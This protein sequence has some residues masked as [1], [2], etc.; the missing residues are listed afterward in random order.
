MAVKTGEV[1]EIYKDRLLFEG[2]TE[3]ENQNKMCMKSND[4]VLAEG[5]EAVGKYLQDLDFLNGEP[6]RQHIKQAIDGMDGEGVIRIKDYAFP[7]GCSYN[8]ARIVWADVAESGAVVRAYAQ[9]KLC[10]I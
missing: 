4:N 8:M 3:T 1:G 2:I 10:S 6:G 5:V 7:H 9:T